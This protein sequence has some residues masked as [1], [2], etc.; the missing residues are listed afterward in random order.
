MTLNDPG[1]ASLHAMFEHAAHQLNTPDSVYLKHKVSGD[2]I[3][4]SYGS[5]LNDI[6]SL[7]SYYLS[8]GLE[9]G[10]RVALCMDNCPEYYSIDQSLQK[11]GLV[12][13]S[14]YTTLTAEETAFILNDSGAKLLFT[15]NA[16]LLKKF[17]KVQDKCATVQGVVHLPND[18]DGSGMV[19]N[20]DQAM[21]KGSELLSQHESA[22]A[23]RYASV[24]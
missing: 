16:F 11:M 13:V 6:Q 19:S 18:A 10:D 2:W 23:D 9:K 21:A 8:I 4:I 17:Q 22:I 24:T 12:N 15:G 5:I 1:F 3:D 7:C 20:Y 14:I